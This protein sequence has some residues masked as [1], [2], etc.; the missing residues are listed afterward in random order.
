[1]FSTSVLL[2]A[3]LGMAA[4]SERSVRSAPYHGPP[5]PLNHDGTVGLTP[6]LHHARAAHHAA[7]A[8]EF[9]RLHEADSLAA[10]NPDLTSPPD[11][12]WKQETY[13]SGYPGQASYSAGHSAHYSQGPAFSSAYYNQGP[14]YPSGHYSHGAPASFNP[15]AHQPAPLNPDGTVAHT[16]AFKAIASNLDAEYSKAIHRLKHED[17]HFQ[18]RAAHTYAY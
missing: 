11:H 10:A 5:A 15:E 2:F 18:H 1:M 9:K 4:A 16:A 12:G 17:P 3:F 13:A 14:S 6:E 8:E 7:Y